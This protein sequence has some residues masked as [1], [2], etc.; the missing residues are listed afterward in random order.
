MRLPE[1]RFLPSAALK[2]SLNFFL[3]GARSKMKGHF[4][5]E[6]GDG[7]ISCREIVRATGKIILLV[8]NCLWSVSN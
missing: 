7:E 2:A 5:D 3:G 4:F 1:I 6:D 8:V